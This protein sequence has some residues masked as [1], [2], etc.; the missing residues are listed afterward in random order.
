MAP[1]KRKAVSLDTKLQILQDSRRGFK[2]SALVKKYKLAQSTVSTILKTGSTA[3]AKAGT[4]GHADQRKRVR[5]PLYADVEEA[6]YNWFLT[7]RARNVPISGPILAAKAKNFAFLLGRPDFEPGGGW[8]QRFKDRHGIV[9]KNVVGEAASL[10]SQAK[11]EW[12]LEKLPGVLERYADKDV[13]NCDETALFFQM[14]PSKTHALKGDPC[15]GG[16]HSKLRVTV[17]LCA[18]MDG[19]HRLK[20]F[21]IGRS[22]KPTCFKNQHIP[23]RYRSNKKAWMTRQLF[24]EWL[25]EV[26]GI[27]EGQGRKV[28][29]LLDNCSA[30]AVS[31]KLTSIELMFLPPNTTAGLQP[32]DA[33]IIANFKALYRRR[34]L[35]WLILVIDRPAPGTSADAELKISLLKAVR[36]VYGAWYE[37]KQS[38]ISNCFKKAG[39]VRQD[40]ASPPAD[41]A[42]DTAEAADLAELWAHVA[43][44]DTDGVSMDEFLTADC[45][46]SSCEEITD[47]AIAGDVLSRQATALSDDSSD[48]DNEAGSST[49]APTSMSTLSALSTIDQLIDFMHSKGLPEVF[50]QQLEG[51]HAAVVKLRLPRKQAKISDYLGAPKA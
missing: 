43:G 3:I 25:L 49:L 35:E 20:P 36:F 34:V 1:V 22:K 39:F 44:C 29:L 6:L 45:A 40:E 11:E 46:A 48:S 37:V 47:E 17:L 18:N 10:D 24:E 15:P 27:M 14:M 21:V 2:V 7:T 32:L 51:M 33:G 30:H 9:Y 5:E 28:V 23:V 31:P 41:S 8:I 19:S 12:L 13:Y 50:A 26:D 42:T 16:K 4:S 38:T